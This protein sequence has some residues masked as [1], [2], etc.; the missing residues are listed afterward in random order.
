[1]A[2]TVAALLLSTLFAAAPALADDRPAS[3]ATIRRA[4]AS[5][6][7][8]ARGPASPR[9]RPGSG[10]AT[11]AGPR[12]PGR[13]RSTGPAFFLAKDG[14]T[15]P[16]AELE[17]TLEGL[18]AP[19]RSRTSSPTRSAASP[20]ACL[21]SARLGLDPAALPPAAA[22]SR[23]TSS[24]ASPGGVTLVFS[25]YYLN[26]PSSAFGHTLLRLDKAEGA[27]RAKH[28]ELLDYGVD[29]AAT[30][31]T[32]NAILYAVK[33]LF[34]RF[35]GQ[36]KHYA[37]YYK[38][39]QYGDYE[40]RDLWEYDLALTPEETALLAAHLWELGGTWFA[41][42]YLDENCSYHVL[43]ALEAAAPRLELLAHVGKGRSSPP[44]P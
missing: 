11:G 9:T 7:A 40:S 35:Q 25:S 6:I 18:F 39:R 3:A 13:A 16:A 26:N 21:L 15:D 24:R 37:Y 34:G 32:P 41:Y 42:W 12:R 10:S 28:F 43:G 2:L 14:K 31:D 44:T 30:V 17:A 29:Y 19:A 23:T 33:G 22:R 27:P 4:A 1:M 5:L 36:F 8:R 20:R 38:V